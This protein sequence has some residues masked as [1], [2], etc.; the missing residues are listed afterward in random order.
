MQ[1]AVRKTEARLPAQLLMAPKAAVNSPE[2][3]HVE[4]LSGGPAPA[5][6][7]DRAGVGTN[8]GDPPGLVVLCPSQR[9]SPSD[10]GGEE[11]KEGATAMEATRRPKGQRV[12]PAID[13]MRVVR[14]HEF[15]SVKASK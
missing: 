9:P 13:R 8:L 1:R 3:A 5:D 4:A 10:R 2:R 11:K 14:A 15:S 6:R 12:L 7:Q